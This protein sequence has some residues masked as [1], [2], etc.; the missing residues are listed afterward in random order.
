M[1]GT[2]ISYG[3]IVNTCTLCN[4]VFSILIS[5]TIFVQMDETLHR[6]LFL[7]LGTI[8]FFITGYVTTKSRQYTLPTLSWIV[9][10]IVFLLS[11]FA[12]DSTSTQE[13]RNLFGGLCLALC[14]V[15]IMYLTFTFWGNMNA[16]EMERGRTGRERTSGGTEASLGSASAT[17]PVIIN[18]QK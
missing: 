4:I 13:S 15:T 5:V 2:T 17:S 6:Y 3:M 16:G 14:I 9:F 1:D 8:N 7:V 10:L 18:I 11:E 12:V